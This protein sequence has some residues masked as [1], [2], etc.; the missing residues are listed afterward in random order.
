MSCEDSAIFLAN[1]FLPKFLHT[2]YMA[3]PVVEFSRNGYKISKGFW[4]KINSSQIWNYQIW[5]IGVVASSQYSKWYEIRILRKMQIHQQTQGLCNHLVKNKGLS[6]SFW[7]V[8]KTAFLRSCNIISK[9]NLTQ[10]CFECVFL[11]IKNI[12]L[13]FSQKPF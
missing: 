13:V 5:R 2:N 1:S 8:C 4:L 12:N 3:I 9:V 10:N 6:I 7:K 11:M